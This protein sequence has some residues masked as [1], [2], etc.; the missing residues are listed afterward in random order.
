MRILRVMAASTR[1]HVKVEEFRTCIVQDSQARALV[2]ISSLPNH[3]ALTNFPLVRFQP[4]KATF[5]TPWSTF[6]VSIARTARRPMVPT[7]PTSCSST[8]SSHQSSACPW[9]SSFP[10]FLNRDVPFNVTRPSSSARRIANAS[11]C[12]ASFVTPISNQKLWAGELDSP[13]FPCF[14]RPVKHKYS[15][16]TDWKRT[17]RH[18]PRS[19][20]TQSKPNLSR[21]TAQ[22]PFSSIKYERDQARKKKKKKKNFL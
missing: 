13:V 15:P 4:V 6:T 19:R 7:I 10:F 12:S 17:Q 14:T 20:G 11:A 1:S 9:P 3:L 22:N 18:S 16:W 5:P 2:T 21:V 8:T